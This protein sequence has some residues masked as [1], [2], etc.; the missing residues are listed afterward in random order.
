M[1]K[2]ILATRTKGGEKD[3]K[4]CVKKLDIRF[5]R[6]NF[7]KNYYIISDWETKKN[8]EEIK[9]SVYKIYDKNPIRP[10]AF[11][12][13]LKQLNENKDEK[14][15]FHLLTY[16]KEVDLRE[17]NIKRM[18]EEIEK[19]EDRLIVVG[20]RLKDNVLNNEERLSYEDTIAYKVPWN[21]CALWNKK[22]VYGDRVKK[23]RF[24]EICDKND[25]GTLEVTVYDH[26]ITTNYEGM[27]DGLVIAEFITKN[28]RL[29]YKLIGDE[30]LDWQIDGENR[31]F[32]QKVKMA[33]KS[34]VLTTF[35]NIKGYSIDKLM[36][37]EL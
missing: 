22:F 4:E 27:E 3:F 12:D 7:I 24:D 23:L 26:Q 29:R 14:G 37:A 25:L 33:R 32:K 35:M 18:I 17:E 16:S 5:E 36:K 11:N 20:Y 30:P 21:T 10:T 8:F 2:I 6:D 28:K 13:V 34:I 19:E 31:R 15:E 1:K 9:D